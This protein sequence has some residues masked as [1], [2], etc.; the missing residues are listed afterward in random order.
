MKQLLLIPS[1][2]LPALAALGLLLGAAAAPAATTDGAVAA[3]LAQRLHGDRTGACMLAARIDAG[4]VERARVCADP[5][6]APRV[7]WNDAFEIGSITKTMTATLL[8]EFV[9]TG[10][11]AL[12]DPLAAWLPEDTAVPAWKNE[13]IRLRHVVTHSSGLP[14]LPPGVAISNPADPYADMAPEAVRAALAR[15]HLAAAPGTRPAY[16]N[17]AFMLLSEAV[18]RRAGTPFNT[19]LAERI[20][21][22]LGMAG[23]WV[24]RPAADTPVATGHLP[25][26]AATAGWHF[27]ANMAG[28]GGVHATLDDLVRYVRAELHPDAETAL[29][30]AL[31]MTQAEVTDVPAPLARGMSW[32][33]RDIGGQR[34]W[35]HEGGTGGYSAFVAFIPG[36]ERGVVLLADT[37]LTDLGGIGDVGLHLL[38][39]EVPVAAPRIETPAPEALL[40][41]LRGDYL[42][43]GGMPAALTVADGALHI[44]VAGQPRFRLAHDS[45]GDFYPL[46]FA[47]LLRPVEHE[48]GQ[49]TFSW[50]QGGGVVTA[51]R[52]TEQAAPEAAPEQ[53]EDYAGTYGLMPGFDLE[54]FVDAGTLHGRATG[55]GAFPLQPRATDSF[56][57][58]AFGIRIDFQRDADGAVTALELHQGGQVLRGAR[59]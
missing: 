8:A 6:A 14:A 45:A 51:T 54:V 42:L 30:R 35:F 31:A 3:V 57:A 37:S 49:W 21:K 44:Q 18:A 55:Q 9:A 28:V 25:T 36:A 2:T 53:L 47:A 59:Q 20:F 17:F 39:L 56:A 13:P 7:H 38:G 27:P 32:F 50:H 4:R 46:D 23:A 43:E 52:V 10:K 22:P 58:P 34:I 29:G 16:S 19:L 15:V 26:G 11:G 41:A 48:P 40:Q 33:I 5:E 24:E 12:D 1:R